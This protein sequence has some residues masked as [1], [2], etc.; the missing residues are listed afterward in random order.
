M[1]ERRRSGLTAGIVLIVIGL[2]ILALQLAPE[3][4]SWLNPRYGWPLIIVGLGAL[5]TLVGFV[6]WQAGSVTG[7]CFLM[8]LGGI[9]YWQNVNDS[10]ASWAYMWTLFPGFT[11]IG[12]LLSAFMADNPR[13]AISSGIWSIFSSAMLF[14][15]FASFLGNLNLLG[16]YWPVLVIALGV[17]ML[18]RPIFKI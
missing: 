1:T 16:V 8:G 12:M 15:I 5:V 10:W 2:G 6:T 13:R 9:L 18:L 3:L 11:G 14:L 7:G 17:A 4:T